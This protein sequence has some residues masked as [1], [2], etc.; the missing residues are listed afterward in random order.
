VTSIV[1]FRNDLRLADNPALSEAA[2]RG[3]VVPVFI[4]APDEEAGWAPGAASRWWLHH[5][6]FA[7]DHALRRHRSRLIVRRG[8]TQGALI[9]LAEETGADAV[10]WNRRYEPAAIE[11][12]TAVKQAVPGA[13]SFAGNV[14][15]EPWSVQN[16]SGGPY[17]VFTPFWR[18]L[19]A[20]G[21]PG[22]PHPEP[23]LHSPERWPQ[24]LQI[25][26]LGLKPRIPW[27]AGLARTWRPGELGA[28]E[29]LE[30]FAERAGRY[31]SE[32]DLPARDA[33]SR[34]SPHLHH[35]ELSVR[36]VWHAV[37]DAAGRS[38]EPFLRQLAWRDFAHHLLFHFPQTPDAPLRP[39]YA[40]MPWRDD[41]AGLRVWQQG[42][43]GYPLVDAGM[44]QLWEMGWMHNRARLVAASF[45][46]KHLL[47]DWREGARWF[48]DTLVDADLANNTLGWQWVAGSGADAAPYHRIFSPSAQAERFDGDGGYRERW[49][50]GDA[51][52]PIVDHAAA[53][54]RAL[55]AH[56]AVT[57]VASGHN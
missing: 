18:A 35:G 29:R 33:T 16:R 14:V 43:T 17:Q 41:P 30:A 44:R 26:D 39:A 1:W 15:R 8:P 20:M 53:R 52:E 56:E 40:R 4:W 5:S 6:L 24:S 48:W 28:M 51:D 36:Q 49:L 34:L 37:C 50:D 47:I 13:R 55:A 25:D 12:D 46:T 21:E 23:S 32:R 3:P 54:E 27:D 9:D 42:R 31:G 2:T 10:L 45:L 11:R 38:A 22:S 19:Q 7:L 57:A